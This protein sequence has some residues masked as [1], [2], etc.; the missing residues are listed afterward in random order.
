MGSAASAELDDVTAVALGGAAPGDGLD[1]GHGAALGGDL[2]A[3]L[4]AGVGLV[5][6]GLRERGGATVFAEGE[7][8]DVEVAGVVGDVQLV[9]GMNF[10]RGFD[11]LAGRLNLS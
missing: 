5:V 4:A 6:E 11:A 2:G 8:F 7:D 9:A 10:A 1:S 3:K